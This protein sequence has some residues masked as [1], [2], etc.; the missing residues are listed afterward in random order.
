MCF[1]V[2]KLREIDLSA[3]RPM[4]TIVAKPALKP[5]PR[6]PSPHRGDCICPLCK[7]QVDTTGDVS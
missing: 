2:K 1:I 6:K 4:V 7:P 3:E 5:T